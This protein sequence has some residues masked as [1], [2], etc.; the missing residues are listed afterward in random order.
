MKMKTNL[1]IA[2]MALGALLLLGIGIFSIVVPAAATHQGGQS[3]DVRSKNSEHFED[4]MELGTCGHAME[5]SDE[6][7][8]C[9]VNNFLP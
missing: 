7:A 9:Q 8:G 3:G 4:I 1:G 5:M 2:V 6:H